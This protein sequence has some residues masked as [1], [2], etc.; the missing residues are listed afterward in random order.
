MSVRENTVRLEDWVNKLQSMGK[1]A[2]S[3]RQVISELPTHSE[4]A[5]NNALNRLSRKGT[6][7]SVH[8]GYY[9]IISPQY[10][11]WGIQPAIDFMDGLMK[12]L[13]RQYYVA[14]LSAA[15]LH[16]SA[17]QKPQEFY[18]IT[19]PPALRPTKK[20]RLKNNYFTKTTIP[21]NHIV[22]IKPGTG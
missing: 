19:Q 20:K 16:G 8:K 2:F 17:H 14:L 11:S 9:L 10:A 13:E 18:V 15:A 1:T 7:L 6:I 4:V 5:I 22:K 12:H 21:E 3:L